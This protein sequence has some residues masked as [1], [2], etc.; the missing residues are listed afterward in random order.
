MIIQREGLVNKNT[1]ESSQL[2]STSNKQQIVTYTI[3]NSTDTNDP[4][5]IPIPDS[6]SVDNLDDPLIGDG[7]ENLVFLGVFMVINCLI[8]AIGML[9]GQ[10]AYA[11]I[12][13][14]L[15]TVFF[16][17]LFFFVLS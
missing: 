7:I 16:M 5:V 9:N 10:I 6:S 4:I 14:S 1:W 17:V 8:L 13:T 11:L 15:M 12:G 3:N 2:S